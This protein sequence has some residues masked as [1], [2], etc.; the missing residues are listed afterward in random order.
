MLMEKDKLILVLKEKLNCDF[1]MDNF[2]RERQELNN[3]IFNLAQVLLL[4][5]A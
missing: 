2:D 4:I 3:R 1:N 5:Q